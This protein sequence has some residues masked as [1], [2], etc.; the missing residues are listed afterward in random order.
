VSE[1]ESRTCDARVH[2]APTAVLGLCLKHEVFAIGHHCDASRVRGAKGLG[3]AHSLPLQPA[4]WH[5]SRSERWVI[6]ASARSAAVSPCLFNGLARTVEATARLLPS[7]SLATVRRGASAKPLAELTFNGNA[8]DADGSDGGAPACSRPG[9]AWAVV[10]WIVRVR[11]R[12][13]RA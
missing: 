1:R 12:P 9:R 7:A 6:F 3:R 2:Q 8:D 13:S 10:M 11:A 4:P 5:S